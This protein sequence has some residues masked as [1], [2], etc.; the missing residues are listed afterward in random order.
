MEELLPESPEFHRYSFLVKKEARTANYVQYGLHAKTNC[1]PARLNHSNF[2]CL[3]KWCIYANITDL[4]ENINKEGR[5]YISPSYLHAMKVQ[6]PFS[7]LDWH[8]DKAADFYHAA[9]VVFQ[10]AYFCLEKGLAFVSEPYYIYFPGTGKS[11]NQ[12]N[13][14]EQWLWESYHFLVVWFKKNNFKCL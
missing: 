12:E 2:G 1:S 7:I 6:K 8:F 3:S 5:I 11:S 14:L 13:H 10:T 9:A 4:S